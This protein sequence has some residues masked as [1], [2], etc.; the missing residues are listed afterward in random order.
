[1]YDTLQLS[2]L[3]THYESADDYTVAFPL[4][5]VPHYITRKKNPSHDN[6]LYRRWNNPT[7]RKH[8]TK[9][10]PKRNQRV[11]TRSTTKDDTS[12]TPT[13]ETLCKIDTNTPQQHGNANMLISITIWNKPIAQYRM[14]KR[15]ATRNWSRRYPST[16]VQYALI[17]VYDKLLNP[18][19]LPCLLLFFTSIICVVLSCFIL[20]A[21]SFTM[22]KI[23][24]RYP[25]EWND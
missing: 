19:K 5:T 23:D 18:S 21:D 20:I 9:K 16:V 15:L 24:D 13:L 8:K 6:Y 14:P 2:F 3:T 12:V 11:L 4:Y 25:D 22:V 17:D 7:V 1:M 10:T